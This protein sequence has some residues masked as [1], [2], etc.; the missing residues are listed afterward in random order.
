MRRDY[1][2][3]VRD[4]IPEIIQ[5]SG[6]RCAIET[7]PEAEYCQAL[8]EKL[9]EEAQ[10]ARQAAPEELVTELADIQEVLASLLAA[11]QIAPERVQQVKRQRFAERGGFERRL[12][13]LW[14]IDGDEDV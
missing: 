8:L 5:K 9:V 2:K 4:Y 7:M 10:E 1:N 6:K 12:K 3:L 14:T 11:W 13:L